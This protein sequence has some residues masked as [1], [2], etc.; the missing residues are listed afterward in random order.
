[1]S[2]FTQH[3]LWCV[4]SGVSYHSDSL[5]NN[6]LTGGPGELGL[7]REETK[8]GNGGENGVNRESKRNE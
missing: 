6:G 1:M 2:Y 8:M 4:T 7:S 5:L 3:S